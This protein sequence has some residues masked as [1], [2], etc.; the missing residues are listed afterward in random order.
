MGYGTKL[1]YRGLSVHLSNHK[2]IEEMKLPGYL[3]NFVIF[4]LLLAVLPVVF[5]NLLIPHFWVIF[6]LFAFLNLSIHLITFWGI[7]TSN[8]AS[9]RTFLGGTGLKFFVWMVFIF[10]YLRQNDVNSV[11]FLLNFF[12]LYFFNSAFEIYCLLRTLRNP[13]I[14]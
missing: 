9:V 6:T 11:G 13:K 1:Y 7:L 2:A 8:K 4:N 10:F 12:Y 14:R 5:K 3:K